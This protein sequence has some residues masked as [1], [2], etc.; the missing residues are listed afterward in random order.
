MSTLDPSFLSFSSVLT[1]V[2]WEIVWCRHALTSYFLQTSDWIL[3]LFK[4]MQAV[5]SF[6]KLFR[7]SELHTQEGHV[8]SLRVIIQSDCT[9]LCKTINNSQKPYRTPCERVCC[10]NTY[11]FIDMIFP[12][13]MLY[14]HYPIIMGKFVA[15]YFIWL[16]R[17]DWKDHQTKMPFLVCFICWLWSRRWSWSSWPCSC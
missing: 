12:M 5:L 4:H 2:Q 17:E 9:Q 3:R 7:R 15:L 14:I 16:H 8:S 6:L 10:S 1:L 11:N 13:V